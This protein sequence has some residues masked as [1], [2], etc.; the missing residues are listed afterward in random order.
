MEKL[1]SDSLSTP[2]DSLKLESRK[3]TLTP[4]EE[5]SPAQPEES[6]P[7]NESEKEKTENVK[8]EENDGSGA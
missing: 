2:T 4:V 1:E 7:D 5:E 6:Q 8:T 3:E